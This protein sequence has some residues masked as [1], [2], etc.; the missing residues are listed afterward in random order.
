MRLPLT[1]IGLRVEGRQKQRERERETAHER[2][3]SNGVGLQARGL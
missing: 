2:V 1:L 3:S